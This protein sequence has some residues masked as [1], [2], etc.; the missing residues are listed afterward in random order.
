MDNAGGKLLPYLTA[1]VQ[2]E[3]E[4]AERSPARPQRRA[5]LAAAVTGCRPIARGVPRRTRRPIIRNRSTKPVGASCQGRVTRSALDQAGRARESRE[6]AH[7]TFRWSHDRGFWSGL[8]EGAEIVVGQPDRLRTDALS[9]LPTLGRTAEE[10][11]GVEE[12]RAWS[13]SGW[14]E[15]Q[16]T[17]RG[18]ITVPV[19]KGV[20]LS[21]K[22][23]EMVALM[24][25]SG[26]GKTTLINLRVS[27]TDRPAA[28]ITLVV[29]RSLG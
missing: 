28:S 26:S 2:F 6:G 14:R 25:A 22:Q 13:S 17:Y 12:T 16:K 21:I 20:S 3:V 23:G 8:S 29:R 19:L 5:P 11:I 1:R 10:V 9:I 4:A 24:G 15:R 27:S 7:W 18:A